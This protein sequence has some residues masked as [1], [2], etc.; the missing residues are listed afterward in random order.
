LGEAGGEEISVHGNIV[1]WRESEAI[2]FP[3]QAAKL[4]RS[5]I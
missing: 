2:A 3:A 1:C 4:P 5:L